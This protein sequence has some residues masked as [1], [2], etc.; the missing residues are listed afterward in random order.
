MT[1]H[2]SHE[3]SYYMQKLSIKL[4]TT[5]CQDT[6]NRWPLTIKMIIM[7]SLM[8]SMGLFAIWHKVPRFPW[9]KLLKAEAKRYSHW[10]NRQHVVIVPHGL[11]FCPPIFSRKDPLLFLPLI[12]CA[13][14]FEKKEN[15][16]NLYMAKMEGPPPKNG[17]CQVGGK[18]RVP[19]TFFSIFFCLKTI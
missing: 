6:A 2:G 9:E 1:S 12:A 15:L 11:W 17:I 19:L 5:H 4:P 3:R 14:I 7:V 18:A 10:R 16:A 13:N 8:G